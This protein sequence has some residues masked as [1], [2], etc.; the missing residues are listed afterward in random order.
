MDI[1]EKVTYV[2][3]NEHEA[4]L[5]FGEGQSTEELLRSY[6]EKLIITQGSRGV[7]ACL[8][9]GELLHVPARKAKVADTTGAGDTLNGAFC[10]RRAAGDDLK[11]ALLYANTAASL[12]TEKFGAQTGMPTAQEVEKELG[13]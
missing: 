8:R 11:A 5:I 2:T 3:P 12:S 10:V 9:S 4:V 1:I 7:S 6:P 13:L